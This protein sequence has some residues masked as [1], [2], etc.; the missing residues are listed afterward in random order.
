MLK[1]GLPCEI[2]PKLKKIEFSGI[3]PLQVISFAP[4]VA[5][6]NKAIRDVGS[7]NRYKSRAPREKKICRKKTSLPQK[8]IVA[9]TSFLACYKGPWSVMIMFPVFMV[10]LSKF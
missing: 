3:L 8:D 5:P 4:H 7:A 9:E 6:I 10:S 1:E 2:D